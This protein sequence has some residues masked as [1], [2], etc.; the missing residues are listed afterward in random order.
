MHS[1]TI[2]QQVRGFIVDNYLLG[3]NTSLEDA[4]SFLE[5]GILDSTGVLQLIAFLEKTY[6]I[7]VEDGEMTPEN[8]D[9][10]NKISAYLSRK[11]SGTQGEADGS[12]IREIAHGGNV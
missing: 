10:I 12:A 3:Q 6:D 9:S 7:T 5:T 1:A 8:L 2:A 11:L 4:D